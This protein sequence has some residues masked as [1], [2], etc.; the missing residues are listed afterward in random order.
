MMPMTTAVAT[1]RLAW[2]PAAVLLCSGC[3]SEFDAGLVRNDSPPEPPSTDGE[4]LPACTATLTWATGFESDPTQLEENGDGEL[5]WTRR[6]GSAFPVDTL[7]AGAWIADPAIPLD[8]QPRNDF[9][10]RVVVRL[11]MHALDPLAAAQFWINVDNRDDTFSLTYAD[12]RDE[13]D[14]TQTLRLFSRPT[15]P[16]AQELHAAPG[17]PAGP[18]DVTL[19]FDVDADTVAAWVDGRFVARVPYVVRP[20]RPTIDQRFATV[21]AADGRAEFEDVR[22]ELC[23]R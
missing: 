6:D 2:L 7:V 22:V 19:E 8:T 9:V 12:L 18:L 5:D 20:I 21:I 1:A 14:G 11:T 16:E 17:L 10:Q 4:P 13:G 3:T 23:E 15:D